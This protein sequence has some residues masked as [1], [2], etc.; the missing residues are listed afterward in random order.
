MT[1]GIYEIVNVVNGHRY[2]G[3]S[4]NIP[5]RWNNHLSCLSR[6][7]SKNPH[8]QRSWN[9]YG[10]DAFSFSVLGEC[11]PHKVALN[12]FENVA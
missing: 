7:K 4:S 6:G 2:I 5:R 3:Q 1:S 12:F 10:R 11:I 9:K 8:L